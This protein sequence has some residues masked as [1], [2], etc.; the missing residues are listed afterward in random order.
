MIQWLYGPYI[1]HFIWN[2][3][4]S[5]SEIIVTK[6]GADLIKIQFPSESLMK[7]HYKNK[8]L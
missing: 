7:A 4:K 6:E 5:D 3:G 8:N 2:N 1:Y